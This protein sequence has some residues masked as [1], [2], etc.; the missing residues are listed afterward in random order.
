MKNL[1][2]TLHEFPINVKKKEF[3]IAVMCRYSI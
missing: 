2:N 1:C 3:I